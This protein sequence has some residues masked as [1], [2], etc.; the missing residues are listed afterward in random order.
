MA[1]Y[2]LDLRD[3]ETPDSLQHAYSKRYVAFVRQH[4]EEF[5]TAYLAPTPSSSKALLER[6]RR[7]YVSLPARHICTCWCSY[8][9][10]RQTGNCCSV[11][12]QRRR[13]AVKDDLANEMGR[14]SPV[15]AP[16]PLTLM[17]DVEAG[18]AA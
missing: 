9:R 18:Y 10:E 17:L 11:C 13:T 8:L 14:S 16:A 1:A 15:H 7:E 2:E 12:A 5:R 6:L 4:L 3:T